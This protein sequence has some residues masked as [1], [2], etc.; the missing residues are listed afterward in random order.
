METTIVILLA[1]GVIAGAVYVLFIK[2]EEKKPNSGSGLGGGANP[3]PYDN[4]EVKDNNDHI[5]QAQ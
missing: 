5:E 2:K 3:Y 1:L 4:Q